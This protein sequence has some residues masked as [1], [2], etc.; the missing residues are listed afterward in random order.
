MLLRV[1]QRLLSGLLQL[2]CPTAFDA[3]WEEKVNFLEKVP[4]AL[5]P[6]TAS[7]YSALTFELGGPHRRNIA[8][9]TAHP[10]VPGAWTLVTAL[11]TYSAV[12][13]GHIILWELGL[14]CCLRPGATVL[15]PAGVVHYSFVRVRSH[16]TRYSVIQW[17]GSGIPRWFLNGQNS[18]A[19]F[20][21]GAS[22]E[23]LQAR[24]QRRQ[25]TH[26]AVLDSFPIEEELEQ[27]TV[28]LRPMDTELA[29]GAS[30]TANGA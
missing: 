17:A 18:D 9:G 29:M 6:S 5:Y 20:A 28:F 25:V 10:I 2:F 15:I 27:H 8:A 24:E 23:Q 30:R 12:R 14:V 3:F 11:G 21:V 26:A 22:E 1:D 7:V 16:E 13:G 4:D 19:D